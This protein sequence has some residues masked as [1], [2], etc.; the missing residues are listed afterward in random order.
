MNDFIYDRNVILADV[1]EE[2]RPGMLEAAGRMAGEPFH[3]SPRANDEDFLKAL[4]KV[5]KAA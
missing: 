2:D 5:A 4:R 3:K 1:P